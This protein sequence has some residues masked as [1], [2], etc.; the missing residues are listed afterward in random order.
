MDLVDI[1]DVGFGASEVLPVLVALAA[2][3]PGQ[4]VLIEQPEL[5]L[6]PSAQLAMGGLLADAAERG[7]LVVAET[8]SQLILRA[9]QTAVARGRLR[10]ADVGLHWFSRDETTGWTTVSRADLHKDGTFG[11]WPVDFPDVYAMADE[12]FIN[13]VFGQEPRP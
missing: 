8:H 6:H 1:A 4:V 2:A 10:P 5:H 3:E 7:V 13:A 9:I 12:Q 11:E